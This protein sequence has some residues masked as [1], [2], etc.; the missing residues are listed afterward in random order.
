ML[1]ARLEQIAATVPDGALGICVFDYLSGRTWQF[2]GDRWFHAAS[3]IKIAVMA[4]VF[5]A[6]DAGCFTADNRLHVRNQFRSAAD[7]R[8]FRVQASR[9]AGTDVYAALGRTMRI[10]DLVRHMIGA[11]SNLATNLLLDFVGVE[12][13]RA[14]LA[15]HGIAG[16][17]LRRGVEDD[18]A[19]DA[20]LNNLV[21]AS[22]LVQLLRVIRDGTG[23]SGASTQ[24][25]MDALTEQQFAGAIGPG[26]PDEIRAVARIAHKTGDISTISHDAGI[27]SLPGRPPYVVALLAES[28]GE[29]SE[30]TA[31][32][33]AA[34]RAVYD[35]VAAAGEELAS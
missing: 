13:A 10:G 22:G 34:S 3:T 24:A 35:A 23:F 2:Q 11:S 8:P 15:K 7:G 12:A 25:M 14:S 33:T 19:F 27:V 4:A 17:D 1:E 18:R 30:R 32:T 6:I 5:D 9:D 29:A 28:G 20:G 16:I 21:T 26:L 31:A